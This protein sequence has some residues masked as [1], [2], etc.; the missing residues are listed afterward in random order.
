M[1]K[2]L[3]EVDLRDKTT[4]GIG[5][6][7]REYARVGEENGV[8]EAFEY[9]REKDRE[10]FVL[11]GGS[12]VVFP[13]GRYE[14]LVV[15]N[16]IGG[17][18]YNG[19]GVIVGSGS[20]LGDL[21][22]GASVKGMAGIEALTGIPGTVGGAIRGNAGAY[23][24]ETGDKLVSVKVFD[25]K[26]MRRVGVQGCGFG[27]RESVFKRKGWMIVEAEFRF[28]KGD[29]RKLEKRIK[30]IKAMRERKYPAGL[31]C[32]GSF[33]KNVEVSSLSE[34]QRSR[35]SV[36][37]IMY[38]KIPAGCLLERVGMKGYTIGGLK[39]AD[40]HANL[41][42]NTGGGK[43]EDVC[44]LMEVCTKRVEE[45]FGIKLEAEV[46]IVMKR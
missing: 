30:E 37:M 45:K 3:R 31:R 39:I 29:K 6:K 33:F 23:G 4:F 34:E 16:E 43:E 10:I 17:I 26:K 5:G 21:V 1:L 41:I 35:I 36:E 20:A 22:R 44:K 11:G 38:G 19:M 8:F 9:A 2:I 40:Y 24:C 13:D 15:K 18:E 27:Y 12:N 32:P 14:G 25:G 28:E 46:E 7:A 42:I